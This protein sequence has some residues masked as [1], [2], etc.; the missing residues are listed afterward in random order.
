VTKQ[1]YK[2]HICD[3]V[4]YNPANKMSESYKLYIKP[5][6]H[7][8]AEQ[9]LN[10]MDMLNI[11]I[12]CNGLDNDSP[13]HFNMTCSSLKGKALHVFNDKATEQKEETMDSHVQCL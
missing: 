7:C 13:A 12:H 11:V 10:F 4:K 5:F 2:D 6:S 9:W 8:T 1:S 3:E